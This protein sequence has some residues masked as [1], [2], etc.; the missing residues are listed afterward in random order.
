MLEV[1]SLPRSGSTA[2]KE[3]QMTFVLHQRRELHPD[4]H[5]VD[6]DETERVKNGGQIASTI[7]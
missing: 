6:K 1:F 4:F 5:L 3:V 7:R 2:A